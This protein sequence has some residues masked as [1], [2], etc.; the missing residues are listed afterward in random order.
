M[1]QEYAISETTLTA[2]ADAVRKN[3][4][5][6]KLIQIGVGEPE[7]KISKTTNATSFT[8]RS[9]GY[10]TNKAL[11]D[12]VSFPGASKIVVDIAYQTEA[13]YDWV[14]IAVGAIS[15]SPS[16]STYPKYTGTT[17][18]RKELIF[19][20]TDTITFYFFSDAS[21]AD[22]LGYYA[23]CRAYDKEGNAF[24][25][26]IYEEVPNTMTV[27]TMIS[28]INNLSSGGGGEGNLSIGDLS[29]DVK[30]YSLGSSSGAQTAI[31]KDI[32]IKKGFIFG[33][34]TV[35]GYIDNNAVSQS[36]D[37]SGYCMTSLF[38]FK[39]DGTLQHYTLDTTVSRS[40]CAMIYGINSMTAD[41]Q[42][43]IEA[44]NGNITIDNGKI[45]LALTGYP[46]GTNYGYILKP[47]PSQYS[48]N[49]IRVR[50][51]YKA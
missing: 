37:Y 26:P 21:S 28:T 35:N 23:E 49:N 2:L 44:N 39:S 34:L 50:Q 22:Y 14:Q 5:E 33:L 43:D 41:L 25:P 40:G 6:T 38:Y 13:N 47:S 15:S 36:A 1:A 11:Y 32:S 27:D 4:G 16:A 20:N 31:I 3:V 19:E 12:V 24:R 9:G 8:T 45:N 7:V 18:T 30:D 46:D 10:G 17:L 51:F 48:I 29:L 42:N